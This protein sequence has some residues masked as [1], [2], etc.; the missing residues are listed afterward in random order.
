M[1]NTLLLFLQILCYNAV[2][3]QFSE[4]IIL[5]SGDAKFH[6][7]YS[8]D[9]NNDSYPDIIACT[10]TE[11]LLLVN[12]K[13]NNFKTSII[14]SN[15]KRGFNASFAEDLDGDGFVDILASK[16]GSEIIWF[17][18][19]GNSTFSEKIQIDKC[20][21]PREVTAAD[22]DNDGDIDILASRN[23]TGH[24]DKVVCYF[25]NGFGE[26]EEVKTLGSFTGIIKE[27][28][29]FDIDDDGDLDVFAADL[30]G[31]RV[32]YFENL[33]SGNFND[34]TSTTFP[35]MGACSIAIHDFDH[36]GTHDIVVAARNK[37]SSIYK[38]YLKSDGNFS[39]PERL[40]F[41]IKNSQINT[42]AFADVNLDGDLE[43]C[44]ADDNKSNVG[45]LENLDGTF[46]YDEVV[47]DTMATRASSVFAID[48]DKDGDD[49]FLYTYSDGKEL[50]YFKNSNTKSKIFKNESIPITV[51]PNPTPD[52]I[53]FDAGNKIIDLA[54][55]YDNG[56]NRILK[57]KRLEN[58]EIDL[59][60]LNAGVY[61]IEFI[62]KGQSITKKI[63]KI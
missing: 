15:P 51:F 5:E 20:L 35:L 9:V 4:K 43:I 25:N 22:I 8:M 29:S 12:K 41:V 28:V 19:L 30:K 44:F 62:I 48:L 52:Y 13:R 24:K 46:S 16:T 26:F 59:S 7:V 38:F 63:V 11:L 27:V 34:F 50:G 10:D 2:Q 31:N 56:G 1:K 47:L 54:F 23:Q 3:S 6:N 45:Y 55:V 42:V 18:N 60:S 36:D 61:Y 21:R 40:F 37:A 53:Q 57:L 33:G 49:E 32:L 14:G 17:K 39:K 58:N